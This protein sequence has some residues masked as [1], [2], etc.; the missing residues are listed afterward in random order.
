M[1]W[2]FVVG[3][4]LWAFVPAPSSRRTKSTHRFLPIHCYLLSSPPFRVFLKI[5]QRFTPT[6]PQKFLSLD[7]KLSTNFANI[8]TGKISKLSS[9]LVKVINHPTFTNYHESCSLFVGDFYEVSL[10]ASIDTDEISSGFETDASFGVWKN[11]IVSLY[12]HLPNILRSVVQRRSF[13]AS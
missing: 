10:R 1:F 12:H 7:H 9:E 8:F 6:H 4:P 11:C 13:R 2:H 3:Y 5:F